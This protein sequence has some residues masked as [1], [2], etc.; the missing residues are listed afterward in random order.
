MA[1]GSDVQ[2][3]GGLKL[4]LTKTDLVRLLG[5]PD[6]EN[7]TQLTFE[8]A[9]KRPM[10]KA[11]IVAETRTFKTPVTDPYWDVQ[12]TI[13]VVLKDAKVVEFEVQH[14]VTY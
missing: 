3:D 12:D 6:K 4:G 13:N 10:T 11:D 8:R 14:I 5:A 1:F 2:T 7:G 9:S